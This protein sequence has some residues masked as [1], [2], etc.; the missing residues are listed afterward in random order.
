M[1]NHDWANEDLDELEE[2]KEPQPEVKLFQKNGAIP[3]DIAEV[4][5]TNGAVS[6]YLE[7]WGEEAFRGS[8]LHQMAVLEHERQMRLGP[9]RA[10]YMKKSKK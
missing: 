6:D 4:W 5:G 8:K 10:T 7:A 9:L 3:K 2:E 1:S